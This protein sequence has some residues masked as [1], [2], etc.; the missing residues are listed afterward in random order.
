MASD[1][2]VNAFSEQQ[3]DKNENTKKKTLY[4]SEILTEFLEICDDTRPKFFLP[5]LYRGEERLKIKVS[6][7]S[8]HAQ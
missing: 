8:I 6:D 1:E 3:E 5:V 2:G 7:F 4:D